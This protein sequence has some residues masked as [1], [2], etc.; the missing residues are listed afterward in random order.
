[1]MPMPAS[2]RIHTPSL[3]NRRALLD[4]ARHWLAGRRQRGF[5]LIELM[6]SLT[7]LAIL[8]T[9]A[10]PSMRDFMRRNRAVAQSNNIRSDLQFARGQAA[11]T[12]SYITVC[13]LSAPGGTACSTGKNYDAGWLVYISTAPNATYVAS[14]TGSLLRTEAAPSGTSIRANVAGP[15]TI[16]SRGELLVSSVPSSTSVTFNVCAK[17]ADAD[18]VGSSTTAVPGIQL[19][20]SGSGRVASSKLGAG[21]SCESPTT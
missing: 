21:A 1:M 2:E 18:D 4:P 17:V 9:I 8:T 5:T 7:V 15:L 13:P 3:P 16:N 6:I 12:R 10:Y 19:S 14:A 11:A 20:A